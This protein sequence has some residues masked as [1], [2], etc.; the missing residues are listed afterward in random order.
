MPITISDAIVGIR[1]KMLDY[2]HIA[3]HANILNWK[4][5]DTP[6]KDS[7]YVQFSIGYINSKDLFNQAPKCYLP[8]NA[9]K[10][11]QRNTMVYFRIKNR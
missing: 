6:F 2:F 3:L 9:I 5:R 8:N 10:I 11:I 4:M 1:F 7:F